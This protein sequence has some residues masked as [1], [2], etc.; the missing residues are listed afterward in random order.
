MDFNKLVDRVKGITLNPQATWAVIKTEP[1]SM[2]QIYRDYLVILAAVPAVALFVGQSL[3]G[4]RVGPWGMYR[5]P[6][7]A[8]LTGAVVHY[9]LTLA[10]IFLAGKVID[11][12]APQFGA[13]RNGRNAFKVAAYSWTPALVAGVLGIVPALGVVM[14]LASLYGAYLL[15]LGLPVLMGC[16]AEKAVPYTVV[17]I[18]A[19]LVIYTVIGIL[20]GGVMGS[21]RQAVPYAY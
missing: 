16:P 18:I 21:F 8:G 6:L 1:T 9:L 11:A 4:M 17:A 3:V 13:S 12:L 10:G 15:Y 19:L 5:Q 7:M 2:A 14:V 20:V